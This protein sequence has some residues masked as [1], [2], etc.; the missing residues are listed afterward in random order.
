MVA[1]FDST[2]RFAADRAVMARL[3][4]RGVALKV[5]LLLKIGLGRNKIEWE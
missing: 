1:R 5:F 4:M 3:L 2:L